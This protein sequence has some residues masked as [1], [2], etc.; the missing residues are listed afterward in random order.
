MKALMWLPV[1][2]LGLLI[3]FG[4]EISDA[5]TEH[6]ARQAIIDAPLLNT[7]VIDGVTYNKHGKK[8]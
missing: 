5:V 6:K 2:A 8:Q 1:A 4:S 7:A 3:L